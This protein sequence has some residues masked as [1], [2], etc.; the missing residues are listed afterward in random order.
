MRRTPDSLCLSPFRN[1]GEGPFFFAAATHRE[2]LARLQFLVRQGRS[3]GILTGVDGTG[4]TLVLAKFLDEARRSGQPAC[5]L[6]LLGLEPRDFLW[7]LAAGL[8]ASPGTGDGVFALWRRISDRLC[9][10]RLLN[11]NTAILLDDADEAAH[12]VVIFVL[13]LLKSHPVGMTLAL[14]ADPA[15]L[16]RLGGDLLQLSQLRIHLEP[17]EADDVRQYLRTSLTRA[18]ADPDLFDDDAVARILE[19][20]GGLPRWVAHLAELT[21]LAAAGRGADRID[22]ETVGS[23]YQELSASYHA[24]PAAYAPAFAGN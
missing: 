4:K 24:A 19:L 7:E 13:R 12:E 23:A 18:G 15:R 20:S 14:A 9:E 17:W 21:W 3:L 6:N 10:N 22:A 5:R 11:L 2:A 8:R 1:A 16:T